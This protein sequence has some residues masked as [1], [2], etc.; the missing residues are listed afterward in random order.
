VIAPNRCM[1][2]IK[3]AMVL[4]VSPQS[5]DSPSADSPSYEEHIRLRGR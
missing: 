3:L 2:R 4:P 1:D 5:L